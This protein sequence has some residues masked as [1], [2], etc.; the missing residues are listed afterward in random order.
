MIETANPPNSFVY[1]AH[2]QTFVAVASVLKVYA[3]RLDTR[4]VEQRELH[5]TT[6]PLSKDLERKL[7]SVTVRLVENTNEN[8]TDTN[9]NAIVGGVNTFPVP[10][11]IVLFV[12]PGAIALLSQRA[13]VSTGRDSFTISI[14]PGVDMLTWDQSD[15]IPIYEFQ[16]HCG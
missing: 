12:T 10:V 2:R 15:S 1:S 9:G 5:V 13:S 16:F 3:T 6:V 8:P 7:G 11:H 4:V 14:C